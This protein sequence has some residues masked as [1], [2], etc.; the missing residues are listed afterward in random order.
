[1][2]RSDQRRSSLSKEIAICERILT[3]TRRK[4]HLHLYGTNIEGEWDRVFV[5][6][7]SFARKSNLPLA[8]PGWN[9]GFEPAYFV[10]DSWL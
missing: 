2:R 9:R 7:D 1:M 5:Q 4:T 8:D 10:T 6:L 3:A